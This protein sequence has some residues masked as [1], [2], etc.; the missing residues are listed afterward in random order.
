GVCLVGIDIPSFRKN[1]YY[2]LMPVPGGPREWCPA[3]FGVCLVGF[4]I[5]SLQQDHYNPPMPPS[6]C[7]CESCTPYTISCINIPFLHLQYSSNYSHNPEKCYC[8]QSCKSHRPYDRAKIRGRAC[9]LV[10]AQ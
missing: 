2:P 9:I 4:D 10:I 3:I 5:L 1:L 7:P 8:M 6:S